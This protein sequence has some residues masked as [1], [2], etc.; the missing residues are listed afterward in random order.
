MVGWSLV[1]TTRFW[2]RGYHVEREIYRRDDRKCQKTR[3]QVQNS[4]VVSGWH[5][6]RVKAVRAVRLRIIHGKSRK[7]AAAREDAA[8]EKEK[9]EIPDEW[10]E[11]AK[12]GWGKYQP[13]EKDN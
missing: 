2:W 5:E 3:W 11:I 7:E 4:G 1:A 10:R 9:A 6:S 12:G 8:R 13:V